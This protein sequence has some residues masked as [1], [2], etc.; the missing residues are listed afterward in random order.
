MLSC[1]KQTAKSSKDS[2]PSTLVKFFEENELKCLSSAFLFFKP[3]PCKKLLC[4]LCNSP[5]DTSGCDIICAISC[6]FRFLIDA[7]FV[8]VLSSLTE[9]SRRKN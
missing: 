1:K 6:G 5:S 7:F 2:K 4:S 8:L 9:I 3:D